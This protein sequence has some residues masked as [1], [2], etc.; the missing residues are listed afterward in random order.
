[1][2]KRGAMEKKVRRAT[3]LPSWFDLKKYSQAAPLDAER[4][5]EQ[6]IVRKW[7]LKMM[8]WRDEN[9]KPLDDNELEILSF[10]R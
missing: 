7:L 8:D 10:I 1:M 6:L 9:E 3:D 5:Y 2:R 4:W